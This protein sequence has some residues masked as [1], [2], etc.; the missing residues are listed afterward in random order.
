MRYVL[1]W[2]AAP[3]R[4]WSVSETGASE[5]LVGVLLMDGSTNLRLLSTALPMFQ[6]FIEH[7]SRIEEA[8]WN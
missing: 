2:S 3:V 1:T 6:T 8:G 4:S 7:C 5:I